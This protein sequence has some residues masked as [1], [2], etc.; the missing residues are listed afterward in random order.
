MTNMT[1][2]AVDGPK[3][4]E[5]NLRI[6]QSSF[7]L[8]T[9]DKHTKV[10]YFHNTLQDS[11]MLWKTEFQINSYHMMSN[12]TNFT[13]YLNKV[14]QFDPQRMFPGTISE[15]QYA[16]GTVRVFPILSLIL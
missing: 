15:T 13:K 16:S 9:S 7:S 12:D 10:I 1:A 2:V 8:N 4:P 6:S 11:L 14:I 5:I 3:S